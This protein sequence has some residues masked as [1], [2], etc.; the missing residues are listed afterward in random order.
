MKRH[1]VHT[2]LCLIP[3]ALTLA[4]CEKVE[5]VDE[6]PAD[7]ETTTVRIL[8]RT[9]TP[10]DDLY[11]L[12]LY[13][14]T[15]DGT[16][17]SSQTVSAA[18]EKIS[19]SIPQG[20]ETRV[21]AVTADE[22]TYTIPASPSIDGVITPNAPQLPSD[23]PD[24]ARTM[25]RGYVTSHPLQAALADLSPSSPTAALSMQLHYQMAS[26]RFT[27]S[28]LPAS[29]GKAYVRVASPYEALA[30]SGELTGSQK[31]VVPLTRSAEGRWVSNEAFLFPTTGTQT[32]FTIAYED[33]AEEQYAQVT[34]QAPL[35]AGVPYELNGTLS[36]GTLEVTGSVTPAQWGTPESLSFTFSPDV[37]TVIGGTSPGDTPYEVETL[38]APLSLW[39]GHVV[40]DTTLCGDDSSALLLLSVA[41][42]DG[43]TSALN[44]ETPGMASGLATNYQEGPLASWRI[45]TDDEARQLRAA[46]LAHPDSFE[47]L[48]A[49]SGGDPVAITD[50]KGNNI[51]YLCAEARHT[52]SFKPGSAYNAI[53]EAGA[54]VRDY[55]LRL[56]TTVRVKQKQR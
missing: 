42:Y 44:A 2:L 14:F 34:Y 43:L 6:A 8:A 28:G 25:A 53:K 47:D 17:C 15:N 3:L 16:L 7:G 35:R 5:V 4:S 46:Y 1:P 56:V 29:C 31:S 55:H 10:S 21:V 20:V 49:Q 26:V 22:T 30:L 48:L 45:P 32:N 13:A 27:L 23:A 19:L 37:P 24:F 33:D 52:Y 38:P 18:D 9:A 11:P 50:G 36:G 54:S 12:R 39:D 41:D 51:R 40:V